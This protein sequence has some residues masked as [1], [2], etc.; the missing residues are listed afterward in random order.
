MIYLG[1]FTK[2]SDCLGSGM[3]SLKV[4]VGHGHVSTNPPHHPTLPL[5]FCLLHSRV[6]LALS[7][8]SILML[9]PPMLEIVSNSLANPNLFY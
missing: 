5:A 1:V 3:C 7:D 6:A 9:S 8:S 2:C 4:L